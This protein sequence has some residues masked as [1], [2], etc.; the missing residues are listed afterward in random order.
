MLFASLKSMLELGLTQR[1][2]TFTYA[3]LAL[4]TCV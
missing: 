3:S 4:V 2:S 1:R